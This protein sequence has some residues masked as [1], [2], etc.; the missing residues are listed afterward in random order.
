MTWPLCPLWRE[1]LYT[2]PKNTG[3]SCLV[4]SPRAGGV[5]RLEGPFGNRIADDLLTLATP[6]QKAN[7]SHWIY[8]QNLEA[9]LLI[10]D[11]P[12]GLWRHTALSKLSTAALVQ[13]APTLDEATVCGGSKTALSPR[14]KTG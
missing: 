6:R 1:P 3:D 11:R 7:L 8:C 14:T 5:Y 4:Y 10:A 12:T 13:R 9:G 2:A